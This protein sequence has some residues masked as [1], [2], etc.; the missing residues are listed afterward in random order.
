[1]RA[2]EAMNRRAERLYGW[3]DP[4][5]HEGTSAM[6]LELMRDNLR[7]HG[8]YCENYEKLLRSEGVRPEMILGERDLALIPAVP[9]VYY[10]RQTMVSVAPEEMRITAHSSGTGGARSFV[11]FDKITLRRAG[12]M[13]GRF[14][15]HHRLISLRPVNYVMLGSKPEPGQTAGAFKTLKG[16][17]KMAPAASMEYMDGI[18][19]R[20]MVKVLDRYTQQGLPI[21]LLG[22]PA[23]LN[24]LLNTLQAGGKRY[25]FPKGSRILMGGGFKQHAGAG[26]SEQDLLRRVRYYLGIKEDHVHEFFSL[27]EHPIP[28][29][30]CSEGYFHVPVYSRAMIR[31][32]VSL[33]PLP[34][35]QAGLLNLVS[36]L[37]HSMPLGSVITDDFAVLHQGGTCRCKN[38]APYFKW[39]GRAGVDDIRTCAAQAVSREGGSL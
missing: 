33:E 32:C 15:R 19:D 20:G 35:G 36:P 5:D 2:E 24:G 39:L 38:P 23:Y 22:F 6:Y 14:F 3:K 10:K 34:Y 29:C 28:Y 18:A 30:K 16:A 37:V 9:T 1:M 17:A 11:G 21:R 4:Y 26:D 27:V 25:R 12:W 13:V 31:D 7:F 8:R